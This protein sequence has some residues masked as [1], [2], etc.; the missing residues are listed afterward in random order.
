MMNDTKKRILLRSIFVHML[1]NE[2]AISLY[3]ITHQPPLSL[4]ALIIFLTHVICSIF[5]TYAIGMHL[6]SSIRKLLV[7][8]YIR[9]F[10]QK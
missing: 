7:L 3:Y 8:L 2:Y 6:N 9:F 4:F 5:F 1:I 10:I